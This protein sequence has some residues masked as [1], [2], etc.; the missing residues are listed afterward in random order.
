MK[1]VLIALGS[2]MILAF[3][4]CGG[5]SGSAA[6]SEAASD[7]ANNGT[8]TNVTATQPAGLSQFPNVPALPEN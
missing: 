2:V 7:G 1:K 5:A 8:G 3:T 6:S 4:G